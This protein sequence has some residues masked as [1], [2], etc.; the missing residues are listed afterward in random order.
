[1]IICLQV[2][3]HTVCV[4]NNINVKECCRNAMLAAAVEAVV[5][6]GRVWCG[7]AVESVEWG[8][9]SRFQI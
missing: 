7:A 8:L 3:C 9:R 1:M 5:G 2:L 4:I 6:I